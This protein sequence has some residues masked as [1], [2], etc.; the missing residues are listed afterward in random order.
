MIQT[1]TRGRRLPRLS[2]P[3][4]WSG[5]ASAKTYPERSN[6]SDN[7]SSQ[8]DDDRTLYRPYRRYG[9]K[10]LGITLSQNESL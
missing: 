8:S 2:V 3:A 5:F 7:E 1:M 4:L 9:W 10:W 6:E